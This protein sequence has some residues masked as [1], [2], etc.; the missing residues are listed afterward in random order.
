MA[1]TD[2]FSHVCNNAL[3][4]GKKAFFFLEKQELLIAIFVTNL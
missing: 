4:I 1:S 3:F 2:Y